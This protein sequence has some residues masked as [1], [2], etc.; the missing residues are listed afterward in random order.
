M[1]SLLGLESAKLQY[2]YF[3]ISTILKRDIV[4]LSD[5]VP[6]DDQ[7]PSSDSPELPSQSPS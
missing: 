5:A 4:E 3:F 1:E 7:E 6:S 2:A